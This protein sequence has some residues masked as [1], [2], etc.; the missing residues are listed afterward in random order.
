VKRCPD[1][2]AAVLNRRLKHDKTCPFGRALDAVTTA[3][4]EWF[5]AHPF[6]TMRHRVMEVVE[7]TEFA[8]A[9]YAGTAVATHVQ[10]IVLTSGLRMRHPYGGGFPPCNADQ[11]RD[12]R[13]AYA[14]VGGEA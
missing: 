4:R 12:L 2:S 8:L 9:G 11:L 10:V 7:R 6:A 1:C 14:R 3:D 5:V 13:A